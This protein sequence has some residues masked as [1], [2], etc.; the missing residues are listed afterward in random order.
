MHNV[1]QALN[2]Y[3]VEI[4]NDLNLQP[5]DG[6]LLVRHSVLLAGKIHF[7]QLVHGLDLDLIG[8]PAAW[9]SIYYVLTVCVDV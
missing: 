9:D 5:V 4:T 8:M 7:A 2:K 3:S 1:I 6:R